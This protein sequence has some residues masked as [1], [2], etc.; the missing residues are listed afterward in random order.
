[1]AIVAGNVANS[2][3]PGYVAKSVTQIETSTGDSGNAV[4]VTSINRLLDTFV[5]QQ[6][7]TES[8]GG[9][10]A[11]LTR[12]ICISNCSRVYGQP[13][14]NTS[15]DSTF[16]SFTSRRPGIIHEPEFLLGA[17]PGS[18]RRAGFGAAA[19]HRHV[20]GIQSLRTQA[21]QGI[22]NDVQQANNA[23]QQIANINQQLVK[24]ARR[25]TAPRSRS[26]ISAINTSTSLR[27]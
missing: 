13:G 14:S 5:Q 3:T 15:L 16:N 21:D 27:N 1:M 18:Q 10:Y 22:A 7:W 2:Q 25:T 8:A 4:Q 17:E 26:R 24:P 9:G 6:L 23:L 11:D 12:L 20:S 19:Q